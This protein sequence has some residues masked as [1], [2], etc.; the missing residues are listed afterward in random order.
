MAHW[1][2]NLRS[3]FSCCPCWTS[4]VDKQRSTRS[5]TWS[6]ERLTS[7]PFFRCSS[8]CQ[9]FHFYHVC[10][11]ISL[12]SVIYQMDQGEFNSTPMTHPQHWL[13]SSILEL[14]VTQTLTW[15][16]N[17]T[18]IIT[19]THISTCYQSKDTYMSHLTASIMFTSTLSSPAGEA[20]RLHYLYFIKRKKL[21]PGTTGTPK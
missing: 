17:W 10:L 3:L 4:F 12:L 18:E 5:Q 2:R 21:R 6:L 14:S 8:Q 15:L 13:P 16:L 9:Y 7:R 1:W 11:N 20:R 19:Q